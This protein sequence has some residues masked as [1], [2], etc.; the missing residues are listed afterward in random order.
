M[1]FRVEELLEGGKPHAS[2]GSGSRGRQT[3]RR[4]AA[5]VDGE[6][7]YRDRRSK[8]GKT[9]RVRRTDHDD[10]WRGCPLGSPNV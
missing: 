6:R 3:S 5:T 10:I 4:K 2:K 9:V 1:R 8:V 7:K